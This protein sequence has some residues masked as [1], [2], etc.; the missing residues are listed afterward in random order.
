MNH[1][2]ESFDELT[3]PQ[4]SAS[5]QRRAGWILLL[6]SVLFH[7]ALVF[8]LLDAAQRWLDR[9][10][11]SAPLPTLDIQ[12]RRLPSPP[13]SESAPQPRPK[14]KP[15]PQAKPQPKPEPE[16]VPEPQPASHQPPMPR[17]NA[18][19]NDLSGNRFTGPDTDRPMKGQA[20]PKR[21]VPIGQGAGKK[22]PE[23]ALPD[24][25]PQPNPTSPGLEHNK[26]EQAHSGTPQPRPKV[27]A[28]TP[29]PKPPPSITS[30][31]KTA[32]TS[33]SSQPAPS[34][35]AKDKGALGLSLE[36]PPEETG[37]AA[38]DIPA[39]FRDKFGDMKALNDD[40]MKQVT[41]GEPFSEIE[42]RRIRMVNLFLRRMRNQIRKHWHL[43]GDATPDQQGEIRF[44]L[45][46]H[47]FLVDAY[48]YLPSGN[49]LLDVNALDAVRAVTRYAVPD[50][51]AVAARYYQYLRFSYNGAPIPAEPE[52][53]S[54]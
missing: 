13:E 6:V 25:R 32:P 21:L 23:T 43:P 38:P 42:A 49:P 30:T 28:P 4:Y 9:L 12:L 39:K 48:V 1:T 50:S 7:A 27:S 10:E 53:V 37:G 29:A 24:R 41:V 40:A 35:K 46:P 18:N 33:A 16:P 19:R 17:D 44:E 26:R 8:V 52:D 2:A 51:T 47:G 22:A 5:G 15:E 45:D 34:Q 20:H 14:A 54:P 3:L 31:S 36:S 11:Q